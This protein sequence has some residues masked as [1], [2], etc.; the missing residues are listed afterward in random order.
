MSDTA[1]NGNLGP[2]GTSGTGAAVSS[3]AQGAIATTTTNTTS[4]ENQQVQGGSVQGSGQSITA[5]AGASLTVN[6]QSPQA[7]EALTGTANSALADE[8]LTSQQAEST[9]AGI[10]KQ[11][12]QEAQN[13]LTPASSQVYK[14]A[15]VVVVG[16]LIVAA[17][18]LYRKG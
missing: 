10:G 8:M 5:S 16:V 3:S 18:Y 14:F 1:S 9:V 12:L 6:Q 17:V 11:A 13:A 7:L 2:S 4:T 15:G